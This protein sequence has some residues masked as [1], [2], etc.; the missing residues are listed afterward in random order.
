MTRINTDGA[1]TQPFKAT[2]STFGAI[3][4]LLEIQWH[5]HIFPRG[6]RGPILERASAHFGSAATRRRRTPLPESAKPSTTSV[7]CDLAIYPLCARSLAKHNALRLRIVIV[8][9]HLYTEIELT[10]RLCVLL[11]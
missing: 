8:L 7:D 3:D 11:N 6:R 4:V 5:K 10:Y 9:I 2:A 1:V